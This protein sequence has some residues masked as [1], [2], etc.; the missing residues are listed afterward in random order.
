MD[1]VKKLLE[2]NITTEECKI[3]VLFVLKAAKLIKDVTEEK[4]NIE[5]VQRLYGKT[6]GNIVQECTYDQKDSKKTRKE[7]Q[8]KGIES[9]SNAVKLVKTAILLYNLEFFYKNP[10]E[11]ARGEIIGYFHWSLAKFY[12]L[13][14][15]NK[16]LDKKLGNIF[17]LLLKHVPAEEELPPLL[18]EYYKLLGDLD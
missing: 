10:P 14:G 13:G 15:I 2:C 9:A 18:E 5:E 3:P 11:W 4:T 7:K 8:I 17:E 1:I 16:T 12:K 6:I